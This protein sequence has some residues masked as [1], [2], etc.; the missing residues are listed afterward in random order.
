MK[1]MQR[2][3][4]ATPGR[5]LRGRTCKENRTT[6][7]K[8]AAV[9]SRRAKVAELYLQA[10]EQHRIAVELGVS[11]GTISKDLD[12]IHVEWVKATVTAI[13]AYK[14]R[15]L[16]RIDRLEREAWE[17]WEQSKQPRESKVEERSLTAG[18]DKHGKVATTTTVQCGDPRYLSVIDNCV[19]RRCKILGL[20][21]PAAQQHQFL[22]EDG[23]PLRYVVPVPLMP[24]SVDQ[25]QANMSVTTPAS[26]NGDAE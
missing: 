14:Q 1:S 24:P 17:Q 20:Y 25:W 11:G 26:G 7:Q 5:G 2:K 6:R 10:W 19:D 18:G 22:G 3:P 23:K 4:G 13:D 15:E 9:L 21:A 12:A 16:R 8:Q